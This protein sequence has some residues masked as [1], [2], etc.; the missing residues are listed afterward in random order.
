[1]NAAVRQDVE[2][3][4]P[5]GDLHRMV[6]R[7]RQAHHAMTDTD[8][9]GTSGEKGKE[10]LGRRHMRVLGERRVFDRPDRVEAHRFG[11]HRLLDNVMEH[12]LFIG[13]RGVHHLC[14]IDD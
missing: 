2:R 11:Q 3:R 4:D 7:R 10:G 6:H 5:L 13:A 14:F 9:A 1:V 8:P 12:A